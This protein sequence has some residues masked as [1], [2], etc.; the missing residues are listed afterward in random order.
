M[1]SQKL[2]SFPCNT[3]NYTT[4]KPPVSERHIRDFIN[5]G[6]FQPSYLHKQF[7]NCLLPGGAFEHGE[8]IIYHTSFPLSPH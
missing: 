6:L 1:L 4:Q 5:E 3:K 7:T 2:K 8:D